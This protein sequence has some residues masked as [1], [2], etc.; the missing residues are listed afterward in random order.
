LHV[1]AASGLKTEPLPKRV[2]VTFRARGHEFLPADLRFDLIELWTNGDQE[3]N[4]DRHLALWRTVSAAPSVQQKIREDLD[5]CVRAAAGGENDSHKSA[6]DAD[7]FNW[8]RRLSGK[9]S[10]EVPVLKEI[11]AQAA[12]YG[13]IEAPFLLFSESLTP[14]VKDRFRRFF[15]VPARLVHHTISKE[16]L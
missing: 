12:L 4:T 5:R 15:H 13:S 10:G 3:Y 2:D 6:R 11:Q 7:H 16:A 9:S 1:Q 14:A 8:Y